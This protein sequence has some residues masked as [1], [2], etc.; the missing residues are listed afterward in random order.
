MA[1][2]IACF[3]CLKRSTYGGLQNMNDL[4]NKSTNDS[5]HTQRNNE[6]SPV[7]FNK[8]GGS[9]NTINAGL[10]LTS[11]MSMS[12]LNDECKDGV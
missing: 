1:S 8:T 2:S 9:D 12:S 5:P 7:Q 6:I 4:Q 11:I 3:S 10:T